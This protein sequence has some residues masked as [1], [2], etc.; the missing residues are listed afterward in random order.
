VAL[1]GARAVRA[2]LATMLAGDGC[3][4]SVAPAERKELRAGTGRERQHTGGI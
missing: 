1:A 3:G 4:W 2:R